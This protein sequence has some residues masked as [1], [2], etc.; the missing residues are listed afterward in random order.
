MHLFIIIRTDTN[1]GLILFY[2][3][4]RVHMH[5][6]CKKEKRKADEELTKNLPYMKLCDQDHIL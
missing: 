2:F 6:T 4:M 3:H 5:M 1:R